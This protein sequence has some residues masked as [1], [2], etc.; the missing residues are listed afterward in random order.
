M[1][2][3]ICTLSI[4]SLLGS[5]S[6]DILNTLPE[7]DKVTSN[8]YKDASQIEQGVNGVYGS[9]Q[10]TGQYK[11]GLL[12]I[13]EI[14][15]DNTFDEVPANDNFTYGEFDFFTIQPTNSLI[16]N[17]WKD[18]YVGIQQANI[19][20]NRIGSITDMSE[21]TRKTR[22]GEMKFLRALMY[23]NLVRIFGDVPLV[24]QETTDV[25]SYFGQS[26]T[27]A[28]EVY[29]FVEGELKEAITLL[30]ATAAQKGRATKGAAMGI[31]GRVLM[32][33]NKFSEALPYLSQIDGLG[34][35][36]LSDV[37][38]IFDV[39]NKNNA[40]IIFDVQFASGLN[41]NSEGSNA[42]QLFSPSGTVSGAKGHNLP[43]KEVYNLYSSADKRR[44]AYIGLTNNGVPYTKKLVKTSSAVDD[45]GSNVVVIRLADVY[46]MMA[47]CYAQAN[48]LTNANL[49]LNKIKTRA[50]ITNVNLTSQQAL[51]AEIDKERRLELIGE[52]HRWFDLV[53]TGKAVQVMTQYFA[54]TP[55]YSTATIDQHNLLMPVPQNQ[56]N[57]DPAI[58]QNPGY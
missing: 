18:N 40:E 7:A 48:D 20:L 11:Q 54:V 27:P 43:T 10:Y 55:G 17:A 5:C 19:I 8:F 38:K 14:P 32:T 50:G 22:I 28:N 45:G 57:T 25:N 30:P 37:T 15:S 51:L 56:I 31:L 52:G 39:T 44:N 12:T 13:G 34:Y 33:R 29:N 4:L 36:L 23:F 46:L 53:R 35:S 58:K 9:L 6:S 41:G 49:Y 21:G 1:K 24:T 47:E 42:F 3:I 16:E 26:R 2:K